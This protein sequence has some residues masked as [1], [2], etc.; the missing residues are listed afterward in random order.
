MIVPAHLPILLALGGAAYEERLVAE[1]QR[2]TGPIRIVRRCVDVA[3][4]IAASQVGSS[5]VAVVSSTLARL[6]AEAVT[7]VRAMGL[8]GG[9]RRRR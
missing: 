8:R 1:I 5:Q 6:D 7:R 9:S 2:S 4:L 3:D